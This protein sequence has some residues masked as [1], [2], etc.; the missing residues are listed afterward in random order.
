MVMTLFL[1][2]CQIGICGCWGSKL[3]WYR[4]NRNWIQQHVYFFHWWSN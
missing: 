3:W 4:W 2:S 1:F